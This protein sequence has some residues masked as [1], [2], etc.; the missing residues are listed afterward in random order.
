LNYNLTLEYLCRF[1]WVTL[2][3]QAICFE[4]ED[5]IH[6]ALDHLP[7]SL[8]EVFHHILQRT[9]QPG[10]RYQVYILQTLVAAFRPLTTVEFAEVLSLASDGATTP[11][12]LQSHQLSDIRGILSSCGSL[13]MIDEHHLTIHLV[14]Q[15]VR[16]FLLGKMV[17]TRDYRE[18]QFSVNASHLHMA[19]VTMRYLA[20]WSER[21]DVAKKASGLSPSTT[22]KSSPVLLPN[23]VA[24]QR[25]AQAELKPGKLSKLLNI[26]SQAKLNGAAATVDVAKTAE[27]LF[28]GVFKK[29]PAERQP[30]GPHLP[31]MDLLAYARRFWMLHS[32]PINEDDGQLYLLW[33]QVL[34]SS[35]TKDWLIWDTPNAASRDVEIPET[36][37]WAVVHSH[38]LLF[39]T[40]LQKQKKRLRLLNSCLGVLLEMSPLPRLSPLMAARFLTLQLFLQRGLVSHIQVILSMRPEFRYNN[41]ACLY[42]AVFARDYHATR[43]ILC[44]VGDLAVLNGLPY[45]LIE[46]SVSCTDVHMTHLLLFHGIRPLPDSHV[47]ESAAALVMSRIRPGCDPSSILI[48][49][50]LLKSWVST[51]LCYSN[52]LANAMVTFKGMTDRRSFDPEQ[53]ISVPVW[54]WLI[55]YVLYV[56]TSFVPWLRW[57]FTL[58]GVVMYAA[59]IAFLDVQTESSAM[60]I[61]TFVGLISFGSVGLGRYLPIPSRGREPPKAFS[62]MLRSAAAVRSVQVKPSAVSTEDEKPQARR[63][64]WN[65]TGTTDQGSKRGASRFPFWKAQ[66]Q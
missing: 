45:P 50:W 26:A 18:W 39:E 41:Y 66:Q 8:P 53:F 15:S 17:D 5:T 64:L 40:V 20:K 51:E 2:Q 42:A 55:Y 28:P 33:S 35:E 32:A 12:R 30:Q 56:V 62:P 58:K 61:F 31:A 23:P 43:A 46:L 27:H 24:I 29:T 1:L 52:H 4:N 49:S 16:Q 22:P 6:E 65:F 63:G 54:G 44:A 13:V 60:R 11:S 34:N 48:A 3:L 57:F 37:L 47:Q 9:Q 59:V 25:A 14:H 38:K 7:K 19:N 21:L 10:K 36:M